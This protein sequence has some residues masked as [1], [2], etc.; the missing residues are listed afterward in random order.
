MGYDYSLNTCE[1]GVTIN[2]DCRLSPKPIR[3]DYLSNPDRLA[4]HNVY[5]KLFALRNY[6]PYL[7]VFTAT[8]DSISYSLNSGFKWERFNSAPVDIAVIG[9]FDVVQQTGTFTFS[10]TGIWYDYL[11]NTPINITTATQTYTLAPGEYHVYIDQNASVVLPVQLVAFSGGRSGGAINLSWTTSNETNMQQYVAERSLDGRRFTAIGTI[12][13]VN[14]GSNSYSFADKDATALNATAEVYY[15]LKMTDKDGRITYSMVISILP[16]SNKN[17]IIYP[18]P[19]KT[20]VVYIQLNSAE[21]GKAWISIVDG[22]GKVHTM[23]QTQLN[24]GST[25]IPVSIGSLASGMYT[26]KVD[27][28]GKHSI[29]QKLVVQH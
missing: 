27:G 4:L 1:D 18:N 28:L 17:V 26:I 11:S 13:A 2:N 3:W 15:R 6:A 24:G 12:G 23:Q 10:H 22:T 19:A 29:T 25:K 14:K 7:P 8:G 5:A 21:S 20:G 9:N 16:L